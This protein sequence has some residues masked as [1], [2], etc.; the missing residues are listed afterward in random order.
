MKLKRNKKRFK[1]IQQMGK[2]VQL[3]AARKVVF[4]RMGAF[5]Q[6]IEI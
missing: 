4:K 2:T 6:P 3:T 1:E 5:L